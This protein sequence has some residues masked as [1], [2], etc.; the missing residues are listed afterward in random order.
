MDSCRLLTSE[1]CVRMSDL[2]DRWQ[3]THKATFRMDSLV[4]DKAGH[5]TFGPVNTFS[6][7]FSPQHVKNSMYL[8]FYGF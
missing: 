5:A 4:N 3:F 8:Y 1:A 6:E 7:Q 2:P